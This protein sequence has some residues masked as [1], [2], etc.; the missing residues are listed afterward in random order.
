MLLMLAAAALFG[1][2]LFLFFARTIT[3]KALRA[4]AVNRVGARLVRDASR[5]H[6]SAVAFLVASGLAGISGILIG[7]FTTLYYDSGFVIGLKAFVGA[8]IGGLVSYPGAA[9]GRA[10]RRLAG[11]LCRV[12][13][14]RVQGDRRVRRAYPDSGL[15]IASTSGPQR[16]REEEEEL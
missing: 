15:A 3:G 10:P 12:L 7:S 5:H 6:R 2:L 14:Q 16:R 9:L 11:E 13:E 1:L 4:T 8:I